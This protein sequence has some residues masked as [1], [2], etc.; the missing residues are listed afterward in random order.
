M[1]PAA[2]DGTQKKRR[3]QKEE[4]E[5]EYESAGPRKNR[6]WD[7]EKKKPTKLP[8]KV[9]G[10]IIAPAPTQEP[11]EEPEQ[12]DAQDSSEAENAMDAE[13]MKDGEN[14]DDEDGSEVEELDM[15]D[16]DSD[17]DSDSDAPPRSSRPRPTSQPK[18]ED[19]PDDLS[20]EELELHLFMKRQEKISNAK[21]QIA[22]LASSV[23]ED[24]EEHVRTNYNTSF[25]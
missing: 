8:L 25:F 22:V 2:A 10:S 20:P 14:Y 21:Q 23:L 11:E 3:K 15:S 6:D 16:L 7:D 12:E 5:T 4:V 1:T 13:E 17:S 9:G 18:E 24:P 19:N